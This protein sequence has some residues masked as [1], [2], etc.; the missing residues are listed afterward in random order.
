MTFEADRDE[1]NKR[2]SDM[3]L[4]A[5]LTELKTQ[6]VL[7]T[8]DDGSQAYSALNA[9]GLGLVYAD[10]NTVYTA[11]DAEAVEIVMHMSSDY[12]GRSAQGTPV[13]YTVNDANGQML[14]QSTAGD[15]TLLSRFTK[16]A[17]MA[18]ATTGYDQTDL[19]IMANAYS[20]ADGTAMVRITLS[21]N[22]MSPAEN[23]IIYAY[24]QDL[25]TPTYTL[26]LSDGT[27][28]IDHRWTVTV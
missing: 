27:L 10:S 8:A 16:S 13:T 6:A 25:E 11:Q 5:Q 22:A 4:T 12:S 17:V 1:K 15:G 26:A 18:T 9:W 2:A 19:S 24:A 14:L 21:N 23:P 20:A 7:M 28:S 3:H